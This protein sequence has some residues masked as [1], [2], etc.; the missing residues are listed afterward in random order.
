M[1]IRINVT[2]DGKQFKENFQWN[3]D[4]VDTTPEAYVKSMCY[5]LDLP[6]GFG[7]AITMTMIEQLQAYTLLHLQLEGEHRV[8]I[9]LEVSILPGP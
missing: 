4:E 3:I 6:P 5:D 7:D 2:V 9:K 1:T 8:P